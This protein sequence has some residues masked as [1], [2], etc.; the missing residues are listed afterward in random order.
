MVFLDEKPL[1]KPKDRD[2]AIHFL[3]LLSNRTHFV[4]TGFS[5]GLSE[6][7]LPKTSK[8]IISKV[9]FKPLCSSLINDYVE[10]GSPFDKAGGYGYQDDVGSSFVSSIEGL[11]SN[12]IGLP[13]EAVVSEMKALNFFTEKI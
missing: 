13:I 1:G 12:V 3:N 6:Q 7:D 2:E 5:L 9:T 4:I 8:S 10:S 11:E